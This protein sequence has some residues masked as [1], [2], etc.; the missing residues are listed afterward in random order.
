[1][2][3][4]QTSTVCP[5]LTLLAAASVFYACGQGGPQ[6]SEAKQV[7]VAIRYEGPPSDQTTVLTHPN[8]SVSYIAPNF[9]M[10]SIQVGMTAAEVSAILKADFSPENGITFDS[11]HTYFYLII[12]F[13]NGRVS[14]RKIR[15]NGVYPG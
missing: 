1:M 5:L 6:E 8:G 4:I 2:K 13:E 9:I 12:R 11:Y 15:S 7:P 10:D 3:I 14:E